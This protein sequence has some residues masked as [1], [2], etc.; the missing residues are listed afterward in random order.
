VR[1]TALSNPSW[2]ATH[3]K[4]HNLRPERTRISYL[5]LQA[6]TRSKRDFAGTV[7][8]AVIRPRAENLIDSNGSMSD[9]YCWRKHKT[10]RKPI[11]C[12]QG[13]ED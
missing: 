7:R 12:L 11:R 8:Q 4:S 2:E 3:L 10:E 5:A 6:T 13:Y 1:P 9:L